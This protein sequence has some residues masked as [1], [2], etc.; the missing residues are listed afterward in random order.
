VLVLTKPLGTGIVTTAIKR[1]LAG[2]ALVDRAVEL[3]S[4]LNRAAGEALAASGAVHALTDVTGFGLLGHAWEMAEGSGVSF[5]LR[6]EAIPVLDGVRELAAQEV[7]P[8]G[9][10]AN[11]RWVKPHV[12]FA[13]DLHPTTAIVLA[14]AQTNGGLFAALDPARA[15]EVLAALRAAGVAAAVIG[16]VGPGE[17]ARIEV[18]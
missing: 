11:L 15:D 7:V 14:D 4:T 8:G 16:D 1:E 13:D 12:R 10:R 2:T 6:A 3:M 9:S 5:R 17:P 18:G